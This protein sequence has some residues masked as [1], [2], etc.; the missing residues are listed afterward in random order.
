MRRWHLFASAGIAGVL[1]A[2]LIGAPGAGGATFT[3]WPQYLYSPGHTSAN[4]VANVITPANAASLTQAWKF[5][6]GNAGFLSSPTVYNGVIY[7]GARNGYFYALN[8]TTGAIIWKRFIG[9]V[10]PLTCGMQ[11]FTATATVAPTAHHGT[12]CLHGGRR[13][14]RPLSSSPGQLCGIRRNPR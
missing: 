11:G 12:V 13:P 5:A 14:P 3:N 7:I 4:P 8:E 1:A 10:Q 9:F 2:G 6:P